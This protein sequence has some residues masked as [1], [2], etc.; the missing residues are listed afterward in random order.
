MS[1]PVVL[2]CF[3]GGGFGVAWG[4]M[5]TFLAC[6]HMVDASPMP[7]LCVLGWFWGGGGVKFLPILHPYRPHY[8]CKHPP[9]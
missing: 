1:P 7:C 4:C 9:V 5:L 2:P 3:R 8:I 6:A